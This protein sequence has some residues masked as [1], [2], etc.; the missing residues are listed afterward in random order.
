MESTQGAMVP[1]DRGGTHIQVQ[2][3]GGLRNPNRIVTPVGTTQYI[4]WSVVPQ[5]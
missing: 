3:H 1:L 5:A 2:L 4:E